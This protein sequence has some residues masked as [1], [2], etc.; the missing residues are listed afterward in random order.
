MRYDAFIS[1]R[2][3][4]LDLYIAKK[5]HKALETF[6]VP[7]AVAK[8]TGKKNIKRVFRDQ[9]ELPIGSDLSDN[10]ESALR[11]S[12]YLLVICSPRTPGSYWVQ[13]EIETFIGMHGR[14][15][16]LAVLIEGEPDESFPSLLLS[17]EEGNPVE[18]LAADVRGI[19][20]R[21]TDRKLKTEV[22]RLASPLLGCSYDDLKQR[23]RERKM[24]RMAAT[25]AVIA[26]GALAFGAYSTYNA[27]L[28]QQNLE[29]KQRNQS[30]Y[31]A[32]TSLTLLEE[33]DRRA[34]V[35][36]ALEAL[37]SKEN[38][39]P[40]VAEAQ[41]ALS[42]A[43]YSYDD[44]TEMKMDRV[45][46]HDL[47]VMDFYFNKDGENAAS[48]D[49]GGTVYAWDVTSGQKLAQIAP[50]I[51]KYG[52]LIKPEAAMVYEDNIIICEG[53]V[54]RSVTFDGEENW[55]V[56]KETSTIYCVFNESAKIATC[57][58]SDN[59]S[60]YDITNGE[61]VGYMPNN[62]EQ[63]YTREMAYNDDNSKFV[64][65]HLSDLE[66]AK[67]G[68]VTVY[69]FETGELTDIET[70]ADYIAN[71][72]FTS[73]DCLIIS[74]AYN[75]ELMDFDMENGIGYL[76][77]IDWENGKELWCNT[78]EY[79]IVGYEAAGAIVKSRNYEDTSAKQMYDEVIM[80]IDDKVYAWDG[81]TGEVISQVTVNSGIVNMFVSLNSGLVYLAQGNG[82]VDIVDMT[83]GLKYSN[84]AIETGKEV[85]D[86]SICSGK[87]LFRSYASPELGVMK[88]PDDAQVEILTEYD[89]SIADVTASKDET[90]YAVKVYDFDVAERIYFY[91]ADGNEPVY[92]WVAYEYALFTGFI[93]NDVYIM[94]DSDGKVIFYNLK[95]NEE[96]TMILEGDYLSLEYDMNEDMSLLLAYSGHQFIVFDLQ[97]REIICD[98]QT[99]DFVRSA[100]IS[101]DGK[102]AYCNIEDK[103]VNIL[104]I[105]TGELTPLGEE[106]LVLSGFDAQELFVTSHNGELLAVSCGDGMLRVFDTK[107]EKTVAEIPFTGINRRFIQFSADDSEIMLQGD[108]YYF[109]VYD[110]KEDEFTHI[111]LNQYYE[112]EKA[113]ADEKNGTISLVTLADMII[114][115]ADSYEMTARI[116]DGQS[117]LP[118]HGVILSG[119][120]EKLY[121]FPYMTLD[122]LK[123]EAERQFS[124]ETLSEAERIKYRVD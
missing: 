72:S 81:K 25:A 119:Y 63:S 103:G 87:I 71:I 18:P 79:Q 106:Y 73:D 98:E 90:Y 93:D 38:N 34:A 82:I 59:V 101:N 80:S 120:Y 111:A 108:D 53:N 68:Y 122:M 21:E 66:G 4:E 26:I 40:Y 35:L 7:K 36:V 114:L 99:D 117:Y 96:E 49:Q 15:K 57:I 22:M 1:Y 13:K 45:L 92:E 94:A 74:Q 100:I 123:E 65:S 67:C 2:H 12:E 27:A 113:V 85:Q 29:G 89:Y 33:G 23:H 42:Q 37:P 20:K 91:E 69:D 8:K 115:N 55:R 61:R 64:V 32:D 46:T 110:L 47:P 6:K 41:Y 17:D 62:L 9:E 28:I 121:Q 48:I 31:L 16:V 76:Q 39:R 86:L 116:E 14:D 104:E 52:F 75:E 3:T 70:K 11:E 60:F 77:K 95:T 118:K 124:D 97:K 44:G 30:K 5:L 51:D 83:T 84:A 107:K 43:L 102:Y 105:A 10:I 88:Y 58:Y 19:S 24:K 50:G 54:L 78:Y 109:K 56:E 112:I